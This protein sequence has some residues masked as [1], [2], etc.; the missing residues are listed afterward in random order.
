M[1]ELKVRFDCV[2]HAAL[3]RTGLPAPIVQEFLYQQLRFM[4]ELVALSCLVAHGDIAALKSHKIGR[5]YSA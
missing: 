1:E 5:S 2:N 4:C 3:G